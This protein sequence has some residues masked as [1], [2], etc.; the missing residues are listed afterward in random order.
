MCRDLAAVLESLEHLQ[1]ELIA[2][3]AEGSGRRD[4][5]YLALRTPQDLSVEQVRDLYRVYWSNGGRSSA[6]SACLSHVSRIVDC[7]RVLVDRP[8]PVSDSR[9]V[10]S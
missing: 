8:A 3:V 9:D 2:D 1:A 4:A 5:A 10:E 6:T 7:L